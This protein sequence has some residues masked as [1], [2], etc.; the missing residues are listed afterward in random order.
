[1][2]WRS[3]SDYSAQEVIYGSLETWEGSGTLNHMIDRPVEL[4]EERFQW[5]SVMILSLK[6]T[7]SCW[8]PNA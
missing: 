5:H 8:I 1:M 3:V 7:L 2:R 4:S 6:E